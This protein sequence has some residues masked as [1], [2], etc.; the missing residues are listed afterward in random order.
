MPLVFSVD[1]LPYYVDLSDLRRL[2][3]PDVLWHIVA[4]NYC[5]LPGTYRY[6]QDNG[7]FTVYADRKSGY[8]MPVNRTNGTTKTYHHR[9]RRYNQAKQCVTMSFCSFFYDV[10]DQPYGKIE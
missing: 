6:P 2:S 10:T 1:V 4:T 3:R 5:S 9:L 8:A 7:T